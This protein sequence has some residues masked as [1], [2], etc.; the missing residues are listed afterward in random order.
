[1]CVCVCVY[2]FI[3]CSFYLSFSALLFQ[4]NALTEPGA[5]CFS[6][7]LSGHLALAT[8][9]LPLR[10]PVFYISAGV[11]CTHSFY[12]G[13]GIPAQDLMLAHQG[14]SHCTILQPLS[15]VCIYMWKFTLTK[16]SQAEVQGQCGDIFVPC[17][18]YAKGNS[19]SRNFH[20]S[21]QCPQLNTYTTRVLSR[22][23]QLAV[24][25]LCGS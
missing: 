6:T 14:L 8:F 24:P 3:V 22:C 19:A 10:F 5:H 7:N 17:G 12:Q 15:Y 1:M 23:L 16:L 11:T 18:L 4:G 21:W 9:L 2:S 13:A 20:A 25:N